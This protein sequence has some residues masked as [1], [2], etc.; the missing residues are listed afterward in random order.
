MD[1]RAAF[2]AAAAVALT[3]TG[4]VSAL[5]LTVAQAAPQTT[6]PDQS[7]VTV[8]YVDQNGNPVPAPDNVT[9]A[10]NTPEIIM[11]NPDG[12]LATPLPDPV[13]T[14]E[15][16]PAYEGEEYEDGEEYEEGEEHEDGE[17]EEDEGEDYE[18]GEEDEEYE[19]SEEHGE[20]EYG[21]HAAV[22]HG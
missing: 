18:D 22:E 11:V 16:D 21:E 6:E 1:S 14:G 10:S 3:V 2:G 20:G 19:E 17:H 13:N 8:E 7:A 12:S 9:P 15:A 5:F 4:G